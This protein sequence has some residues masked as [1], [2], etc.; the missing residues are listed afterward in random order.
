MKTQNY[1]DS[2][3]SSSKNP[4]RIN[5]L[6]K[7]EQSS[8]AEVELIDD[9]QLEQALAASAKAFKKLKALSAG[10]RMDLLKQL[11]SKLRTRQNEFQ[12]LLVR[13]AGKPAMYA[14]AEVERS[15]ATLEMA[16]EEA[17]H[18]S[19]EKVSVDYGPGAG[20]EA[21]TKRFP[22]G[23]IFCLTPFNFPLNLMMHKLA[24]ALAIGCPVIIK[25]SPLTPLT[26]LLF[27]EL[28]HEVSFPLGSVQVVNTSIEHTQKMI[29]DSRIAM[30]SFTGSAEIG[31]KLKA[32]VPKKKVILELGGNAAVIIDRNSEWER[33]A[34]LCAASAYLYS[35]QVCI[36]TQRIYVHESLREQFE[37]LLVSETK[38]IK[39]G[40]PA[41]V[42]MVAGPLISKDHVERVDA[43]IQEAI[44]MGAKI[45][46]KGEK[47]AP[48]NLISPWLITNTKPEM[49]IVAEEVF[50]P[51]A[52][53]ESFKTHAEA[54]ELVNHSRYGLQTGVFTNDLNF[55]K[56]CLESLEVGAVVINHPP[57][58][59]VDS[60]P[61]GG[62][63]DSGFG[64]EGVRYAMEEMSEPRLFIF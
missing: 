54:I 6:D 8:I 56:E 20:K 36:S 44:A 11:A 5:V 7:Y 47:V 58:F 48:H 31:W 39:Y 10:D 25:S 14:K 17:R 35:G 38:K 34:R 1:I 13:E 2:V 26:A 57:A 22:I 37:S 15:L 24:P 19:G 23:P 64:R 55:A 42:E 41:E 21:F 27:A 33:A 12:D 43:W 16:I 30:I 32:M 49:K 45:L 52:I 61:Y 50:G 60:M 62:V 40:N 18:F 53:L 29:Q 4:E 46:V 59:R 9:E 28:I 63:K 3:W 51:V